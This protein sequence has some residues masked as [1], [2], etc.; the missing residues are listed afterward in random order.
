VI[1]GNFNN[2]GMKRKIPNP[3]G[4]NPNQIPSSN[5]QI[6]M[7]ETPAECRS[8]DLHSL[9][10]GAWALGFDWDLA[11]LG[12]VF[13]SAPSRRYRGVNQSA[14]VAVDVVIALSIVVGLAVSLAAVVHHLR[15]A[16]ASLAD[17]RAAV[18]LAEHALLNLQHDQPLPATGTQLKVLPVAGGDVPVGFRWEQVRATVRGHEQSLIGI[19]PEGATR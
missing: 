8:V 9:R 15:V 14:F 3:K 19:V 5:S 10:F 16:E 13:S 7:E 12:L 2:S 11:P 18:H 17:S 1:A 4:P 6:P